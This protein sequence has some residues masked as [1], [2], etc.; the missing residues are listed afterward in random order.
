[1]LHSNAA[2][3]FSIQIYIL[4]SYRISSELGLKIPIKGSLVHKL[5][6]FV[7]VAV[8]NMQLEVS[9]HDFYM[10]IFLQSDLRRKCTYA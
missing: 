1:M 2:P 4:A 5:D 10:Q 7:K 8:K 9:W 3:R 6:V